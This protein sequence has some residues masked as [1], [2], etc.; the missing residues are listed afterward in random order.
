M[1]FEWPNLFQCHS[2]SSADKCLLN[3][4]IAQLC[5][6]FLDAAVGSVVKGCEHQT[7][8]TIF[9]VVQN[10]IVDVLYKL[11]LE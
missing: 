2:D 5:V 9:R 4:L 11:K 6:G 3:F 7:I 1:N 8:R 10:L